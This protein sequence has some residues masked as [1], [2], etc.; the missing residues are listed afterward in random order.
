MKCQTCQ[1]IAKF[2]GRRYYNFSLVPEYA[3]FKGRKSVKVFIAF[4]NVSD[5]FFRLA[6]A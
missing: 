4:P 2:V 5:N 1:I 6:D 3:L